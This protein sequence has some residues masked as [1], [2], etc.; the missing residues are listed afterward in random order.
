METAFARFSTAL[1]GTV[2][3]DGVCPCHTCPGTPQA[4]H[5]ARECAPET[6]STGWTQRN[7]PFLNWQAD[8]KYGPA[9]FLLAAAY[10]DLPIMQGNYAIHQS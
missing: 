5:S 8:G 3:R 7:F 1:P 6:K 4:G 2:R 10:R 9:R